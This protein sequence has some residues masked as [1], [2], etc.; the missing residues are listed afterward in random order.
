MLPHAGGGASYYRRL[1]TG[2]ATDVD[3]IVVQY[4]G[5][6]DRLDDSPSDSLIALADS[7]AREIS[8]TEMDAPILF[9]HSMGALVAFEV[10]RRLESDGRPASAPHHIVLS[11]RGPQPPSS[12]VHLS[13]D[14]E[15]V[16]TIE[17]LGATPAGLLDDADIRAMLLGPIRDDYRLVETYRL[18]PAPLLAADITT[19]AGLD[20]PTVET[21]DVRAWQKMTR[22]RY[23][24]EVFPGGHFFPAENTGTFHAAL[25]RV[26][27]P[28]GQI[29]DKRCCDLCRDRPAGTARPVAH[30]VHAC[31]RG[32]GR[33]PSTR[34]DHRACTRIRCAGSPVV[35]RT[36]GRV[37]RY[38]M[39]M[40]LR[41]DG[42][43]D[44]GA[45][46]TCVQALVERHP[47]LRTSF[48]VIDGHLHQMVHDHVTLPWTCADADTEDLGFVTAHALRPFDLESGPLVRAGLWRFPDS[49][50]V[51]SLVVHHMVGDGRSFGILLNEIAQ[52]YTYLTAQTGSAPVA[53]ALTFTDFSRDLHERLSSGW[54]RAN[55]DGGRITSPRPTPA[56]L[57]YPTPESSIPKRPGHRMP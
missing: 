39:T 47:A 36:T 31:S 37:P 55:D 35:R 40:T 52:H 10:A 49:S 17:D 32:A 33:R 38:N 18:E 9:G 11:G 25:D 23:R 29:H 30:L 50:H 54:K 12:T 34:S 28:A 41:L 14:D 19:F 43:P 42:R 44:I 6:E 46:R 51:L 21:S 4:P 45:L 22:G 26:M 53:P 24:S 13:S 5:R 15:L 7:I 48:T 3:V 27:S 57:H 16:R 20:D 56:P 1:A 2:I 8:D